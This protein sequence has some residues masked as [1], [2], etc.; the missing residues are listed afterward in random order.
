MQSL[1]LALRIDVTNKEEM[2]E[3]V[4][5]LI[6]GEF[7]LHDPARSFLKCGNLIKKSGRTGRMIEYRFFLFSDVLLYASKESEGRYKIHEE[8]PLHLMKVIDWF[9]RVL[10][11]RNYMFE[12]HHPRKTFQVLCPSPEERKSWVEDIR[13]ELI[14]EM[15]RK[16]VTEAARASVTSHLWEC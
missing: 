12:V 3:A 1:K 2:V 10:K 8:L 16:M 9:P 11:N 13:A 14:V 15:E 4:A 6:N 5:E 7:L